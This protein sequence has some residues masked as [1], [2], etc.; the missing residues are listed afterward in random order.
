MGLVDIIKLL[1]DFLKENIIPNLKVKVKPHPR[2]I[3]ATKKKKKKETGV[4]TITNLIDY[5]L[6]TLFLKD[7]QL[8][9][10][11]ILCLA[12]PMVHGKYYKQTS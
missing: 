11:I 6:S 4:I 8:E 3:N 2:L 12:Y 1:N 9:T 5:L 10:V 7:F